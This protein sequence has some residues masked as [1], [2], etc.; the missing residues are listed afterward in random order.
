MKVFSITDVK[1]YKMSTL[2]DVFQSKSL[3]KNIKKNFRERER[4]RGESGKNYRN[5]RYCL[6]IF[7]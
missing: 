6:Y 1:V 4:E 3:H 2:I 7:L 5:E